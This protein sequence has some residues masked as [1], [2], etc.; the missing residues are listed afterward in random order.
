MKIHADA[1]VSYPRERAFS[2]Y[3]DELPLLVPYLPNVKKIDVQETEDAPGGQDNCIRKLNIWHANADIPKLAQAVIKPDMLS[4]EDHALWDGEN[5]TCEWR[6]KTHFFSER[7]TCKGKNKFLEQGGETIL[8]IR[9]DLDI[10]FTGLPGVP[11]L[12]SKKV[13][14]VLERFVVALLTPNLTSVSD[15]LNHYLKSKG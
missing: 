4:W 13:S 5:W 1:R 7:V 14:S 8:Q 6:V 3:R 9:G 10:D 2:T 15:G 12:I 11:R